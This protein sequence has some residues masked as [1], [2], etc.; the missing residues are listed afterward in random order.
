MSPC[1]SRLGEPGSL[2]RELQ[3]LGLFYAHKHCTRNPIRSL[4]TPIQF[5]NLTLTEQQS[6]NAI[7]T[8]TPN[9]RTIT[10]YTTQNSHH[11]HQIKCNFQ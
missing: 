10:V 6:I 1:M 11:D 5:D 8:P 2:K 3:V 9:F 7:E 4:K